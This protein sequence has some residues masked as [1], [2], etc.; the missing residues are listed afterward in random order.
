MLQESVLS[1]V[2]WLSIFLWREETVRD[3]FLQSQWPIALTIHWAAD[4]EREDG[5]GTERESSECRWLYGC[6][7]V[8]SRHFDKILN[9]SDLKK[10]GSLW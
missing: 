2:V 3:E 6:F 8:S 10:G 4:W 9:Q 1:Y 5:V 7:V